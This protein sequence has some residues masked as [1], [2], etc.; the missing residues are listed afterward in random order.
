MVEDLDPAKVTIIVNILD[1][2]IYRGNVDGKQVEPMKL[3]CGQCYGAGAGW[4]RYFFG[5]SRSQC[6]DEKAKTCFLLLFSLFLYKE[7]PEPVKKKYLEPEP[8]PVK[9]GPA[10]QH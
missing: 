7:E 3:D 2:N 5:Q 4:S 1:N 8:E 10:P 9:S 6:K